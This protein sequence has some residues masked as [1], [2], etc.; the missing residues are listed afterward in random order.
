MIPYM[1]AGPIS[2][3]E[4]RKGGGEGERRREGE[5]ER[6]GERDGERE[7]EEEEGRGKVCE[8]VCVV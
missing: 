7:R 1:F 5:R 4:I 2:W 6:G 8:R 3:F